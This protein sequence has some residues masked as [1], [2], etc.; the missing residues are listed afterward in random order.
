MTRFESEAHA[1]GLNGWIYDMNRAAGNVDFEAC[2]I[3]QSTTENEVERS[4]QQS[5]TYVAQVE[6]G[7]GLITQCQADRLERDT[8]DQGGIHRAGAGATRG[9][10]FSAQEP[11]PLREFDVD[12]A[13]LGCG[14]EQGIDRLPIDA[15]VQ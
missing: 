9:N 3:E 10:A 8:G 2:A 11:Q 12:D 4:F 15:C 6:N 5:L 14:I 13:R 7:D 1:C